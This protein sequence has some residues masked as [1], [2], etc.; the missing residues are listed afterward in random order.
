MSRGQPTSYIMDIPRTEKK[1]RTEVKYRIKTSKLEVNGKQALQP[2]KRSDID[3]AS[4]HRQMIKKSS[5][6][7]FYCEPL[8][9]TS[10]NFNKAVTSNP[11]T[12][13]INKKRLNSADKYSIKLYSTD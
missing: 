3:F 12:P 8:S 13:S 6:M 1:M 5:G 7:N 11:T 10:A 4:E 9:I 2:L